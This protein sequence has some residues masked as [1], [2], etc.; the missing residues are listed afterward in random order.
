MPKCMGIT[1]QGV[2]K[3]FFPYTFL[4]EDKLN[5][6][7]KIPGREFFETSKLSQS[8]RRD[9]EEYY[10]SFE[11]KEYDIF[12]ECMNYCITDVN[13]LRRCFE[14]FRASFIK[15]FDIDCLADCSTIASLCFTIYKNV[16][17]PE[18]KI[19]ILSR[20]NSKPFTYEAIKWLMYQEKLNN[21]NI[22][23][24]R[25]GGEKGLKIKNSWLYPDGF[26]YVNGV[27]T[28]FLYHGCAWHGHRGCDNGKGTLHEISADD[29]Y[30]I[31]MRKE[32]LYKE[33]GFNVVRIW[34]CEWK[35]QKTLTIQD[36]DHIDKDI[37]IGAYANR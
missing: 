35:I 11:N 30:N 37:T 2:S 24:A 12:E 6:K 28:A 8:E 7:G 14:K 25:N 13:V 22:R 26:G 21:I 36:P 1:D 29:R 5:Y 32:Q 20:E 33:A 23:H 18:K 15:A 10:N 4:N 3:G 17:M 31:T 27:K 19:T 16:F 9:F 34:E